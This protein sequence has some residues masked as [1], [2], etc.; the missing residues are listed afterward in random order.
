MSPTVAAKYV[1]DALQGSSIS[2]QYIVDMLEQ[3]KETWLDD[4]M[5]L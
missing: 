2:A 1:A 5:K 3:M 4:L